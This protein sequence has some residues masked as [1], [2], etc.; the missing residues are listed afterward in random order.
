LPH[1][2]TGFDNEPNG[3]HLILDSKIIQRHFP[4]LSREILAVIHG[5]RCGWLSVQQLGMD[6]LER[7]R[8][9]GV[10]PIAGWVENIVVADKKIQAV[11]LRNGSGTVTIPTQQVINAAGPLLREVGLMIGVGPPRFL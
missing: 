4:Y 10:R 6:M 7:A 2:S 11:H 3:V 8:E 5:R 1:H 9:N